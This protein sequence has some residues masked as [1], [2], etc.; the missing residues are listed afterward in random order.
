MAVEQVLS[1]LQLQRLKLFHRLEINIDDHIAKITSR[2]CV[3]DVLDE[4]LEVL[5][6]AIIEFDTHSPEEEAALYYVCGYV[7][8]S[9]GERCVTPLVACSESEFTEMVSRGKLSHPTP[10]LFQFSR[11]AYCAMK[12]LQALRDF[13]KCANRVTK[14]FKILL[15]GMPININHPQQVC[16]ILSNTFHKGIVNKSKSVFQGSRPALALQER[17]LTKLTSS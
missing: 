4:E 13:P 7:A 17:Q 6:A 11:I 12:K 3:D 10:A 9:I 8:V 14:L 16:S 15:D 2:C 5:D 1:S